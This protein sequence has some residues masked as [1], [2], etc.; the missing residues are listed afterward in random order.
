MGE[1]MMT[2]NEANPVKGLRQ[3]AKSLQAHAVQT[4]LNDKTHVE[5]FFLV[6]R[7]GEAQVVPASVIPDREQLMTLLRG[8]IQANDVYGVIH[9]F[10]AW[11]YHRCEGPDHTFTQIVSGEIAV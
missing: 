11:G 3:M 2:W 5:L 4:F 7:A 8:H 1:P 9:I 6:N 10:E